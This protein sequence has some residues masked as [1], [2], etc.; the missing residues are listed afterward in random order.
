[1]VLKLNLNVWI[2]IR[3]PRVFIVCLDQSSGTLA[4]FEE[5]I[6]Q[7][8]EHIEASCVHRASFRDCLFQP[9]SERWKHKIL[10]DLGASKSATAHRHRRAWEEG[11]MIVRRELVAQGSTWAAH[12]HPLATSRL[13]GIQGTARQREMLECAL[14]MRCHMLGLNPEVPKECKQAAQGFMWDVSQ[15]VGIE[16]LSTFSS[17]DLQCPCTGALI[18]HFECDRLAHPEELASA[19]GWPELHKMENYKKRHLT[20]LLGESQALPSLATVTWAILLGASTCI[21]GL[22]EHA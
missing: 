7:W 15:N 16:N 9:G 12:A 22:W 17:A 21:P 3:R 10:F 13:R 1:M 2:D 6:V 14:M 18:Y 4:Q 8:K 11:T 19:F 20:N 5:R